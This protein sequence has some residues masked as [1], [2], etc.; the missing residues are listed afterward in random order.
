VVAC[1]KTASLLLDDFRGGV[2]H[3][4]A[5]ESAESWFALTSIL[6]IVGTGSIM[7]AKDG[8]RSGRRL[9]ARGRGWLLAKRSGDQSIGGAAIA[10]IDLL[11]LVRDR[12]PLCSRDA[13]APKVAEIVPARR[14]RDLTMNTIIT[15]T[16]LARHVA[17]PVL[18]SQCTNAVVL[19]F[20]IT[21]LRAAGFGSAVGATKSIQTQARRLATMRRGI[22]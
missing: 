8:R 1:E 13:G 18:A 9:L 17:L 15:V 3:E 21:S 7:D 6:Y 10:M 4:L 12:V 19:A 16:A 11:A 20:K 2:D 14:P 5:R 22:E